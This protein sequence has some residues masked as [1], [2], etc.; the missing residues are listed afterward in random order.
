MCLSIECV[1]ISHRCLAHTSDVLFRIV[2]N[3]TFYLI[4]PLFS[5]SSIL[6]LFIPAFISHALV[7]VLF[8]ISLHTPSS[9]PF[10]SLS[11]ISA[12]RLPLDLFMSPPPLP[13][14]ILSSFPPEKVMD[15]G[16]EWLIAVMC[17]CRAPC[18]P[19]LICQSCNKRP[20]LLLIHG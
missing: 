14:T 20:L 3:P 12:P 18:H 2:F 6:S 9:F 5:I 8:D 13:P 19:T 16:R 4:L 1:I 7:A 15:Q 17:I 11:F 10:R